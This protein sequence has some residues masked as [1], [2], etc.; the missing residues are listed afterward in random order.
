MHNTGVALLGSALVEEELKS[1]VLV[2]I[3]RFPNKIDTSMIFLKERFNEKS[4]VSFSE[5]VQEVWNG[6]F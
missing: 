2:E 1:G 6:L 3:H 5:H 4:I